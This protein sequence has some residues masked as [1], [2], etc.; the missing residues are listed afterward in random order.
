VRR[1]AADDAAPRPRPD[2]EVRAVLGVINNL[3]R[4]RRLDKYSV[5]AGR[6]D[7]RQRRGDGGSREDVSRVF[8]RT[9][10]TSEGRFRSGIY[11]PGDGGEALPT[12]VWF[13]GGGFALGCLE[14][15]D[16]TCRAIANRSG[17]AVVSVDYRLAPEH[18]MSAGRRD[19]IAV[20]S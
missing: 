17:A 20:V 7:L 10:E 5:A 1:D 11:L 3:N 9:L 13:H 4:R 18:D 8:D 14:M 15:A 2:L 6:R 19:C 12:F 16:G